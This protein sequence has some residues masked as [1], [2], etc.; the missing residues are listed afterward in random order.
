[1]GETE[2]PAGQVQLSSSEEAWSE[3]NGRARQA[4]NSASPSFQKLIAWGCYE[5]MFKNL[6]V[7][8]LGVG[9]MCV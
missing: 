2:A 1:M 9:Q 6:W 5:F 8:L 3:K 7:F 4:L